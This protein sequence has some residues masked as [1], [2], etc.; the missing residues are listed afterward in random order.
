MAARTGVALV[1]LPRPWCGAASSGSRAMAACTRR[2]P[3]HTGLLLVHVAEAAVRRGGL[4]VES[5]GGVV[6]GDGLLVLVL[7]SVHAAEAVVRIGVLGSRA[8]AALYVAWPARTGVALGTRCRGRG[9]ARLT[10]G[11]ERWRRVRGD[12]LLVLVL[13]LVH[14]AEAV[15]RRGELGVESDGGVVR[16]DGLLVLVLLLVHA[17]EAVVRRG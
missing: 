5:D 17:A 6:R 12:G 8:M 3:A 15:V 13:L 7:L 4:G 11:R 1:H 9:A 10:W 2:W 16:G 14:V